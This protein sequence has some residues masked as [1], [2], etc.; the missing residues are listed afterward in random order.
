MLLATVVDIRLHPDRTIDYKD[1]APPRSREE[2]L[3]TSTV[4]TRM[5]TVGTSQ[6]D[7]RKAYDNAEDELDIDK[8]TKL[9]R[10][11]RFIER[12]ER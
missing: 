8:I 11:K 2:M 7:G 4:C 5:V 9:F 6:K 1:L 12:A 3:V 10:C